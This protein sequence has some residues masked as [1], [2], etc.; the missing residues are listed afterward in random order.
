M[1][2]QTL[3]VLPSFLATKKRAVLFLRWVVIVTASYLVLFGRPGAGADPAV[4]L[5]V[6]IFLAT[7]LLAS[8]LPARA[9]E[10]LWLRSALVLFDAAWIS[11]GMVL[12]GEHSGELFLL[13][14]SVLFVAA[15]GESEAM[16]A[17]GSALIA[18]VYAMFLIRTNTLAQILTPSILLRFPFLFGIA[19]VLRLPRDDRQTGAARRGDRPRAR[20]L[21]R[22]PA[23]D[24]DARPPGPAVRDRRYGR[25]ADRRA[26]GYGRSRPAWRIRGDPQGGHGVRRAAC[27]VLGRDHAGLGRDTGRGGAWWT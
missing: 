5:F 10:S 21:P 24:A 25:G 22:G 3:A 14:F 7:N 16:I 18:V 2:V 20:A 12:A 23:R 13:Y 8:M 17:G 6:A 4:G 26:R 9:Y 15:L 11:Y 27:H 19:R 1:N